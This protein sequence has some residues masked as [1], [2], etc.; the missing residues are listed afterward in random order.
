M[1]FTFAMIPRGVL[2]IYFNS[3]MQSSI[4][5]EFRSTI[6]SVSSML[7]RFGSIFTLG[8]MTLLANFEIKITTILLSC[9][10]LFIISCVIWKRYYNLWVE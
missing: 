8:Y 1:Y 6:T 4:K 9:S 5:N 3:G 10:I 2:S 7:L